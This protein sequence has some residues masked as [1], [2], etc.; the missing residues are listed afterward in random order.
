MDQHRLASPPTKQF[1]RCPPATV[2]LGFQC[3]PSYDSQDVHD[4]D[5]RIIA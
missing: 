5:R 3:K 2:R 1:T 4:C